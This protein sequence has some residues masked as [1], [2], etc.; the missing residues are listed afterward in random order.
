MLAGVVA[1]GRGSWQGRGWA[2]CCA[3]SVGMPTR[4]GP[5]MDIEMPVMNGLEATRRIKDRWP[6]VRVIILT[7]YARYRADALASGAD[8][9]LVKGCACEALQHAILAR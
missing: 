7:M 8:V 9:F 1:A 3:P 4:R 5:D 2:D 6:G